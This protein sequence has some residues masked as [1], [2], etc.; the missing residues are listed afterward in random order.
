M[1]LIIV[2]GRVLEFFI[3]SDDDFE[4]QP[5]KPTLRPATSDPSLLAARGA[6]PRHG[7]GPLKE[8]EGKASCM[9]WL[10][11]RVIQHGCPQP[12]SARGTYSYGVGVN[13]MWAIKVES[14]KLQSSKSRALVGSKTHFSLDDFIC[15]V[16]LVNVGSVMAKGPPK[17]AFKVPVVWNHF[18][19]LIVEHHAIALSVD[20]NGE[21]GEGSKRSGKDSKIDGKNAKK[22]GES[23]KKADESS[24]KAGESSKKAGESSKKAVESSDAVGGS[25]EKFVESSKKTVESSKRAGMGSSKGGD[26]V[27]RTNQLQG[28]KGIEKR[29]RGGK[30]E[31]EDGG[32]LTTGCLKKW[33][34]NIDTMPT[35]SSLLEVTG[36]S[37]GLMLQVLHVEEKEGTITI[38]DGEAYCKARLVT[39][40]VEK[41][42]QERFGVHSIVTIKKTI[43][44]P[45]DLVIVSIIESY[46]KILMYFFTDLDVLQP[47]LP[48]LPTE[49]TC[50][51]SD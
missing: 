3:F 41:L 39:K 49:V 25:S 32:E 20:V 26:G 9:T 23:S 7:L 22:A 51:W 44:G 19:I 2:I 16:D 6:F 37:A 28:G 18:K 40:Y 38:T 30:Y 10:M 1:N 42:K 14:S 12:L 29:L 36:E 34:A 46:F 8:I 27:K 31:G 21:A 35:L 15:W 43:G 48:S 33:C 13:P 11:R 5:I 47:I 45:E 50:G 17:T 4:P 24:K